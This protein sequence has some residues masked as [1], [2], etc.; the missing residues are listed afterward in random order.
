MKRG[1]WIGLTIGLFAAPV[2]F[3]SVKP[4]PSHRGPRLAAVTLDIRHRVFHEFADQQR[5]KLN[6]TFVVGDTD[7]S[8]R[9]VQ[10]VPDFALDLKTH[11]VFS[12]TDQP[13]NP[14]FKI[15][16]WQKKVPQDTTWALLHLPPHF[17]RKSMLAFHVVRVDFLD[18]PPLI[19][20]TTMTSPQMPQGDRKP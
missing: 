11:R 4:V 13:D 6:Q 9:V 14:A 20:D 8:A 18:R 7:L 10:Y 15:I 3:A 12:K 2:V 5:V 19:A 1:W 16:V 17:S